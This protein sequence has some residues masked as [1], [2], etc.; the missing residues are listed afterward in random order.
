MK[1]FEGITKTVCPFYLLESKYRISCE[2]LYEDTKFSLVFCD[3]SVKLK[4]Q[5]AMCFS[6]SKY[7]KCPFVRILE[8]E[9]YV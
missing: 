1:D 7:K 5:R 2:G 6:P 8:T 9:K 4:W 3:E